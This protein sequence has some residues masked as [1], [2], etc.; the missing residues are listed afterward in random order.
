MFN[1]LLKENKIVPNIKDI[2]FS[3]GTPSHLTVEE[4]SEIIQNLKKFISIVK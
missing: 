4:I 3:G 2:H 1:N